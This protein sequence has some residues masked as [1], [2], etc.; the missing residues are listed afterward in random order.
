MILTHIDNPKKSSA[1]AKRVAALGNYITN[2]ASKKGTEK[3]TLWGTLNID[4]TDKNSMLAEMTA[5]AKASSRSKDPIDHWII[6]FKEGEKPEPDQVAEM[7]KAVLDD[8]EMS[9]H[10]ALY[11]LHEDTDNCHI[12]IMLN[13]VH[14][15]LHQAFQINNG[16]Y[17]I[18]AQKTVAKLAHDFDFEPE[19]NDHYVVNDL[20]EV[21]HFGRAPD[22]SGSKPEQRHAANEKGE[23]VIAER[24]KKELTEIFDSVK[25]WHELHQKLA[26]RGYTYSKKSSGAVVCFDDVFIK[27]SAASR[28]RNSSMKALEKKLGAFQSAPENINVVQLKKQAS[29]SDEK[30]LGWDD[31]QKDIKRRKHAKLESVSNLRSKHRK[32]FIDLNKKQKAERKKTLN[33]SWSGRSEAMLAMRAHLAFQAMKDKEALKARHKQEKQ[34]LYRQH[35]ALP[36]FKTWL[37]EQQGDEIADYYA[38]QKKKPTVVVELIHDNSFQR[39]IDQLEAEI[40]S[41]GIVAF[42]K[43]EGATAFYEAGEKIVLNDSSDAAIVSWLKYC[44]QRRG[45]ELN[46]ENVD[47]TFMQRAGHLAVE[48]R[49]NFTLSEKMHSDLRHAFES[50]RSET[51]NLQQSIQRPASKPSAPRM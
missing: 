31:Y 19:D 14:P 50:A 33:V 30:K 2:P 6:S 51:Q 21:E 23:E 40:L 16:L 45:S 46:L 24:A 49:L 36:F 32:E 10:Q 15:L 34:A 13:R 37:A 18:Q 44:M 41:L 25:S 17:K 1:K 27:A 35:P 43:T 3:C 38:A 12:H 29:G 48:H 4:A 20:G 22:K 42:K 39:Y 28:K 9:E 5:T 8:F 7:V 11:A 26:D 47:E